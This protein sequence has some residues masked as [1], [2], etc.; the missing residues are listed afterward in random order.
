MTEELDVTK[1]ESPFPFLFETRRSGQ[2][3]QWQRVSGNDNTKNTI[4]APERYQIKQV[5]RETREGNRTRM[6]QMFL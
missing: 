1:V 3:K 5:N 4:V 6:N 2:E